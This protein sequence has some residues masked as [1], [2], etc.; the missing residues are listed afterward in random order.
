[1]PGCHT[2]KAKAYL[3]T[4]LPGNKI[5]YRYLGHMVSETAFSSSQEPFEIV[6]DTFDH[7]Y[8]SR[9]FAKNPILKVRSPG[10][11]PWHQHY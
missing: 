10:S 2:V 1:M 5:K 11:I 7:A 9:S 4:Y 8:Y 3:S 6:P